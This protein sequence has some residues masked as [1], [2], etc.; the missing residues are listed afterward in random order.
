M[1]QICMPLAGERMV[2]LGWVVTHNLQSEADGVLDCV[3]CDS[4]ALA[5][6]C[7]VLP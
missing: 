2:V 7:S 3:H 4:C 6:A 5:V 1:I